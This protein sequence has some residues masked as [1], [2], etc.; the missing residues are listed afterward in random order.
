MYSQYGN[1]LIFDDFCTTGCFILVIQT[2]PQKTRNL[3]NISF[4][5]NNIEASEENWTDEDD[6]GK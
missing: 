4:I 2:K 5:A 3:C 1:I 6:L